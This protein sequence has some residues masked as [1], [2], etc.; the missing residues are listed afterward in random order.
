MRY[1][2]GL[3][4]FS[5][6][7]DPEVRAA[8]IVGICKNAGKTSLLN[9]L[10]ALRRDG[11]WGVFSTGIDGEER[12][13]VFRIPKPAVKLDAGLIFCCDTG[14]L[15]GLGSAVEILEKLHTAQHHVTLAGSQPCPVA[16]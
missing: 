9:H 16:D 7:L 2:A 4:P 10:L 5:W 1:G 13:T 12:D 3:G 6:V 11:A 8:A 14:A 15:N